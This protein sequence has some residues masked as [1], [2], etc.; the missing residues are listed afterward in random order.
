ME[1][2]ELKELL[3]FISKLE[4]EE[5][6]IENGD[7]RIYISKSRNANVYNKIDVPHVEKSSELPVVVGKAEEI[8]IVEEKKKEE[9][10][11]GVKITAPIV[12]TFYEAPAPGS[13]PFVKVGDI[14]K[15][16][17]TLCIIEAMKVMNEIEAEFDCKILEQRV[18]NGES[19]EFGQVL[20]IVEPLE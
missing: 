4:V 14:V 10:V 1:T 11:Q 16:G 18:K 15:K 5:C 19:V 9:I 6:E 7:L 13:E 8:K 17:Q 2:K 3:R 12:G 20:Y